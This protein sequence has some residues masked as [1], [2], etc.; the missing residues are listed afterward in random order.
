M[1]PYIAIVHVHA[2]PSWHTAK[3]YRHSFSFVSHIYT[4]TVYYALQSF[5]DIQHLPSSKHS[6][7][8]HIIITL[9]IIIVWV[10][11]YLRCMLTHAKSVNNI[12]CIESIKIFSLANCPFVCQVGLQTELT[13]GT[14]NLLWR[15]Q[16]DYKTSRL[17]CNRV[18][19]SI[20][21]AIA[22]SWVCIWWPILSK[23]LQCF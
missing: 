6:I 10:R 7:D 4:C 22:C 23:Q 8:W 15:F 1:L 19:I 12:M 13:H 9:N 3:A 20:L 18:C 5:Y 14:W 17:S 2:S 16:H 21:L 11:T